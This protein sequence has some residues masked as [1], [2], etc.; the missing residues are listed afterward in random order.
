[1]RLLPLLVL[2]CG[3]AACEAKRADSTAAERQ[4]M[5]KAVSDVDAARAEAS[6]PA[7]APVGT[8]PAS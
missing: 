5:Q 8:K 1:M 7:T 2:L 3:L 4:A 6:A